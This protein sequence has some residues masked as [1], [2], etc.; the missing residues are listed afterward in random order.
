[1]QRTAP[2]GYRLWPPWCVS[3]AFYHSKLAGGLF[4]LRL[5]ANG[6]LRL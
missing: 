1:V 4:V 3:L 5:A 2:G 6:I